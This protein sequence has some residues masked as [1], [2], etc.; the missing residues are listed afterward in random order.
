MEKVRRV[1]FDYSAATPVDPEVLKAM[2]PFFTEMYG[3]PSS[4]HY[5]GKLAKETFSAAQ[6]SVGK[7][8]G[9]KNPKSEIYFT[10][11]PTESNNLALSGV[12]FKNRKRGNH[13][14]ISAIEHI[15]VINISKYLERNGFHVTRIPVDCHGIVNI[16]ALRDSITEKT[17]L[18]SIMLANNE[19][20]TVQPID[21]IGKIT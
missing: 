1:N 15:S 2:V 3:N 19:I 8:I 12:A 20:G 11:S 16:G 17:I 7:I 13:I 18:S 10:S 21:E 4:S 9:A 14:V 6:N 5:M